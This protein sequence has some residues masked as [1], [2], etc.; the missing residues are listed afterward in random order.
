MFEL[1]GI[2]G[3]HLS[4]VQATHREGTEPS[5]HPHIWIAK[6]GATYRT[7]VGGKTHFHTVRSFESA[8]EI[9]GA[10]KAKP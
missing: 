3:K 9:F 7:R 4:R 6:H 2:V 8:T 10:A 5:C 1:A